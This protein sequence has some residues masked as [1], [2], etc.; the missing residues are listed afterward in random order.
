MI[1]HIIEIKTKINKVGETAL[2]VLFNNIKDN[3]GVKPAARLAA[4]AYNVDKTVQR[5]FIGNISAKN[6]GTVA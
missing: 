5:K 1:I 4:E 6:T 2:L 3:N